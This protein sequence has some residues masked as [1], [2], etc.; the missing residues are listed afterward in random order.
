FKIQN[1]KDGY[2]QQ[3][4]T[5]EMVEGVSGGVTEQVTEQV[6]RLLKAVDEQEINSQEIMKQ[7][8]LSHRPTFLYDYL[9]PSIK[10]GLLEMKYPDS[11]K[12]PKQ[13]YR[14]SDKARK[15]KIEN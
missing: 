3:K 2:N 4:Q 9:Q 11:P 12:S 10:Q 15:L 8:G 5:T 13:K 7:L 14:L 1:S 6:G